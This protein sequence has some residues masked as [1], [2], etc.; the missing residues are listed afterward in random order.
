[1][2]T[3]DY[4]SASAHIQRYLNIDASVLEENSLRQLKEA[5]QK[6][7]DIFN[8]K[9]DEAIKSNNEHEIVR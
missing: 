9:L 6:L 3:E 1:M 4:E 8:K 5:E 2:E 7:K